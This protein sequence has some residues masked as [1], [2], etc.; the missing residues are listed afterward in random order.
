MSTEPQP[1]SPVRGAP[2]AP[3]HHL[4]QL[5]V[6]ECAAGRARIRFPARDQFYISNG[7]VQGGIV[8]TWI[9]TTMAFA[10]RSL[11]PRPEMGSPTIE[12]HITYLRPVR[13]GPMLAEAQVVRLGRTVAYVEASLFDAHGRLVARG[14]STQMIR[15]HDRGRIHPDGHPREEQ[16]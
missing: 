2:S 14:T 9:D 8:A 3:I 11:L 15:E 1:T 4:L 5:E 13:A 7:T 6:L 16:P 12:L 10:V